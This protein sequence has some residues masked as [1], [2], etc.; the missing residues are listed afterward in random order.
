MQRYKGIWYG[1]EPNQYEEI[2]TIIEAENEEEAKKK[3]HIMYGGRK[4][5]P[6]LSISLVG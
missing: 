2:E 3:F 5:Y 6:L 1:N 4:P